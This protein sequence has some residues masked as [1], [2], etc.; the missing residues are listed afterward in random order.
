[1]RKVFATELKKKFLNSNKNSI[2]LGD[3][4]VGLFLDTGD[5]LVSNAY[6]MGILE[7]SMI[8]FA[9]GLSSES[10][11]V[12]V[13]TISPFIIERGYEQIKLDISYN[14]NKVIL[15]SANGPF[16]YNKLG[17]THHCSSD[18]PL[19]NLLPGIDIYLPG[20]DIEVIDSLDRIENSQNA[21]YLRL[22][23]MAAN[24]IEVN[25]NEI[26]HNSDTLNIFVGETINKLDD[27]KKDSYLY[28]YNINDFDV[29]D[30]DPFK[31]INIFEP[32]SCPILG[33]KIKL[34]H[35][36]KI[37]NLKY[38]PKSIEEGIF[39]TINLIEE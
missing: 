15:V 4:S 29:C 12:F 10:D 30:I 28:L 21:A 26:V 34:N 16:E 23:N 24:H 8:S 36:E 33:T 27:Y 6:N 37:I 31:I 19:L 22:N 9:A 5:D 39:N 13:H 11:N 18:V 7:Q 17:P 2:L 32:Y 20:R 38:Y 35:K 1:V 14:K 25:P 3:I